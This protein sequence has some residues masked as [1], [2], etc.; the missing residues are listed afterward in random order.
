MQTLTDLAKAQGVSTQTAYNWV[1][2]YEGH[3][4]KGSFT[5][6]GSKHPSDQRKVVY[7]DDAIADLLQFNGITLPTAEPTVT[8]E[9]GNHC[10]SLAVPIIEGEF[11]LEQFRDSESLVFDDPLSVATQFLS[12]ADQLIA[13]MDTDAT[14]REQRLKLTRQAREQV[15]TK[16][17]ELQLES[18]LYRERARVVDTAQTTETDALQQALA[19]LQGLGKSTA[20]GQG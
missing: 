5:S 19:T 14:Q 1:D 10:T 4:G 8:V 15:C 17:Q 11:S 13:A 9:V 2:R 18:R 20:P 12:V 7:S 3:H 6:Q 16:A